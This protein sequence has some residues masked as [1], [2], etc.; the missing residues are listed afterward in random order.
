MSKIAK[1]FGLW[2]SPIS[3]IALGR[4]ITLSDVAWAE[5]GSLVWHEYRSERGVL[6]V[7][8][9][10][11]QAPR[12]LNDHVSVRARVGYGGGDFTLGHGYVYFVEA[13]LGRIY[14]QP[15]DGGMMQPITP[16]F[17]LCASP[18]L[19]PNGD[20]L[21]FVHTLE[22]KDC[23]AVVDAQGKR[24]PQKWVEGDDFYM[25][26]C[27]HP[28]SEM[29]AWIAW[30]F[31]NMPWD[32]TILCMGKIKVDEDKL[33]RMKEMFTLAGDER[34]SIFQPEFSPDG[35]ALAYVSD[36]NGWWQ[37]YLYDLETK[38]HRLLTPEEVDH[39]LPAWRQGMRTYGFSPDGQILFYLRNVQGFAELWQMNLAT[40]ERMRLPV[41]ADYTWLE[42]IAILRKTTTRQPQIALLASGSAVPP[43]VISFTP[44]DGVR[45][46]RRSMAEDL[47][48]EE[49]STAQTMTWQ[50]MDGNPVHGLYYPPANPRY[51][52]IG[53]PPL[54]VLIHGGPT[55][56]RRAGF[57]P[58]AQFFTSR[59]YAVLDV[60]Y[61]GSTGYGRAYWE[62][63]KGNW[64]IYDVQDAVSGARNLV[65]KGM[66]DERR[67]VIMGGSAGGFTVLKALEDYPGFFKAGVCLYGVTNHFTL[68]KETHKF[69]ARYLDTLLGPLPQ[70]S[71]LYRQRSPLFFTDKIQD[72]VI[73][74]QGEED[75]VVPRSQSDA[76]VKT[77]KERNVP[78]E[79]HVYPGEGHGFRK[80][81]TIEH[82]YK[83]VE[84]FLRH[85]VIF[86]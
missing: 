30:N 28:S 27:W 29:L 21:V 32:G 51:E 39:G 86:A 80:T 66:V 73:L 72:A 59:G 48:A 9:P 25:Q 8:R 33:P 17:G 10:D 20:W 38:T 1:Q 42:Q 22:G 11:G 53:K 7:Q 15:L 81:E 77:L 37:I 75:R 26:P 5:D 3:P 54:I 85:Y 18:S 16:G 52:G 57:H 63:L 43:R 61:R 4:G 56:Q 65:Q 45:V 13:E 23:L 76:L 84:R 67:L 34:T 41:D 47:P 31:P 64:G 62:A 69:E 49:Y 19:S 50:G 12:D 74:F 71:E 60:N 24:W 46:W 40:G 35:R 70:S 2:D 55:S 6:V 68:A 79:Y 83:T 14:R 78:H 36:T 44:Q 82:F 58:Q